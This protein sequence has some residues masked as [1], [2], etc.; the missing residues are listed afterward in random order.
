MQLEI[1]KEAIKR[2]NDKKKIDALKLELA[3]LS[4]KRNELK[5]KWENEK[6][7]VEK[8]QSAK[9]EIEQLKIEADQAERNGDFGRVAEIR[10]GKLKELEQL[11]IDEKTN[12]ISAQS[13]AIQKLKN[14]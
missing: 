9:K 8:I 10:Y 3:E 13:E 11:I 12:L 14:G 4:E 1:E 6:E 2:E 5:T 7:I